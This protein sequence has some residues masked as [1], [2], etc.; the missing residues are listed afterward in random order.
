MSILRSRPVLRWLVPAAA[1]VAVIGGGAAI[2]TFAAEAE[3]SLP[4]RTAAQLLV[5][6]QTSRLEGL[7]GTV[8]QRADL[9]LP[10][11]VGLVPGNDLTTLLTGTHTLRVWYSGP[12]RQR[13]ALLDTL[14]EQDVIRNGRDV[15]T[16]ESR[17]NT[18]RH[19]TLGGAGTAGKPGGAG[20]AGKPG[21]AATPSLPATPQEA[22]DLALGAIDPST[23]VS[24]GRSAT[25]AGRD[26]Y[27]LV[28]QPRDSDSLVHQLRI[29]IDAQQH[30]PL[31]FEVLAKGSDQPAFEMAFTQVDY[32]RPDADQFAFN[33]PP[34]VT[35]TEETAERP[36][37]GRPA[38]AEQRG[39]DP[40]VRTVGDGWATVLVARLDGTPGKAAAGKPA[41]ATPDADLS[42]LLG[43]LP[44]V[45]G[46]WGSG[47][48]L[49]GKL[50]SVLLTDDG[51]V[52]A[53]AVTPERLYQVA[54]G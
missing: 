52:L 38:Q 21:H 46:D 48:L 47:R 6:L 5:D 14:G 41:G 36:S 2:G 18:A 23:E 50:F 7:S 40:Q 13:V 34:G 26:A 25:V 11:L 12:E 29:A 42:K 53:G 35:V 33:P 51:R 28:L 10:P 20:T 27:E 15:W 44:A 30:V 3:P 37:A 49:T 19:R 24:V 17:G 43:G 4:P 45:R 9:G 54:R 1:G 8:V 16:W 22:A 31:R 39:A 32:R